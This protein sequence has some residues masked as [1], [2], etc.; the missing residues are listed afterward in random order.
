MRMIL[1]AFVA[2]VS[3]TQGQPPPVVIPALTAPT[4]SNA[5]LYLQLDPERPGRMAAWRDPDGT[6]HVIYQHRNPDGCATDL[7]STILVDVVGA[8]VWEQHTGQRCSPRVAISESYTRSGSL[9]LWKTHLGQ[10]EAD[11]IGK[12]FYT[13]AADVPEERALLVRALMAAGNHLDLMPNGNARLEFI[14]T[15]P[16]KNKGQPTVV[17]QFRIYGVE[18]APVTVWVDSRLEL[19]ATGD[20]LIMQGWE[21]ALPELRRLK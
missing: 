10:G 2:L 19:F 3:L 17:T 20:Y 15:V 4:P 5:R 9:G 18:S 16:L 8:P 11:V 13:S 1:A 7:R 21:W 6:T 14:R 12:K